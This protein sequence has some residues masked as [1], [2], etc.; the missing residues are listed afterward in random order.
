MSF[1]LLCP[2]ESA[3]LQCQ[4]TG[5]LLDDGQAHRLAIRI[6]YCTGYPDAA[7]V[8]MNRQPGQLQSPY[9]LFTLPRMNSN[10]K[11]ID[12]P[13]R[14]NGLGFK[15]SDWFKGLYQIPGEKAL[16]C[17]SF[18]NS[19]QNSRI[20]MK[21]ITYHQVPKNYKRLYFNDYFSSIIFGPNIAVLK[22]KPKDLKRFWVRKYLYS[23]F[24][25]TLTRRQPCFTLTRR[26]S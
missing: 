19:M 3:Q 4:V 12:N 7:E 23:L 17:T 14:N 5:F 25:S 22:G 26:R 9:V 20:I 18:H 6:G 2:F 24:S 21:S 10:A 8:L 16:V 15:Q 11:I 13:H 1:M